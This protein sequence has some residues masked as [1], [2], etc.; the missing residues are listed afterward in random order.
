MADSKLI[1]KITMEC[2][3]CNKKHEIEERVR[4][5][6]TK[7]KGELVSYEEMFHL[8]RNS[9]DD[10]REFATGKM[11]SDNLLN[12]RNAYKK[13][14]GL[15]TSNDIVSIRRK[16]GLSQVD[17]SVM[18]GWGEATIS[19]YESKAIQDDAYDNMLRIVQYYPFIALELLRKNG[20][21]FSD[22]KK[23]EVK[24][25]IM[26]SLS[27]DGREFLGRKAL[28]CEYVDFMDPSEGNGQKCLDIDKLEAVISYLA[29]RI[30]KLYKV[31]LMKLL[32][33]TDSLCYKLYGHAMTGL[34]YRHEGMGA[35]PIGHY[36]IGGLQNVN[37]EEESDGESIKYRFL[38]SK[39]INEATLSDKEKLILNKVIE[40]FKSYNA[41][42]IISYMHQETAYTKTND[43]EIIPF[44]LATEI[45]DF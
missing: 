45:R 20:D 14:H 41:S 43:K 7:I 39:N 34:V 38:P 35:L 26:E 18:L 23:A 4:I 3:L 2:P 21:Q 15:L 27:S 25:H 17:L 24:Q 12:A 6:S 9:D 8:C 42:E 37:M 44:S 31:K 40:K 11:E 32:W 29:T 19:R 13:A 16:Y 33:Y 22:A 36:K 5:A 28:E 10:E 1:R 30:H